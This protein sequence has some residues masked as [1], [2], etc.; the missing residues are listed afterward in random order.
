MSM[1][2]YGGIN[3]MPS[4]WTKDPINKRI[5][6]LWFDMLRRCYDIEQIK[7]SKGSSYKDCDV[8]PEWFSLKTFSEDIKKLDG[9][10]EWLNNGKMSL[11]KD[12]HSKGKKIY[13]PETC[14]FVHISKN[15][16]EMISRHPNINK[17][18]CESLKVKYALIKDGKRIEFPS[19]KA[20]CEYLGVANCSVASCFRKGYKCKGF[21]I[22]RNGKK[23]M[24]IDIS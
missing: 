18:A 20:A 17:A 13:S 12:I 6:M 5:Y 2:K 8:C 14:C 16:S 19:E 22:E 23:W 11:D 1:N 24:D 21:D 15:I 10:A 9:Y 3:D 4:G 7:R